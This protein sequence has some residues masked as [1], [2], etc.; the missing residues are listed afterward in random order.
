[1]SELLR[2]LLIAAL[3]LT[4]VG[5]WQWRMFLAAR[6]QLGPAVTLGAVGACLQVTAIGQVVTNL[7]D[8]L[9]IAAYAAGV[10]GGVLLGCLVSERLSR[11]RVRLEV[12]GSSPELPED[13]RA[14]GWLA[15]GGLLDGQPL[16]V[17]ADR[18]QL[19]VLERELT[20]LAP[21]TA[22]VVSELRPVR[23][24]SEVRSM[25]AR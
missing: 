15:T 11:G 10:G 25:A 21:G 7:N 22:W 1:M 2:P 18:R 13:L 23:A 17:T 20:S 12:I 5:L 6:G 9:S 3:V 16:Y 19:G 14:R 24:A 8:P 4:E